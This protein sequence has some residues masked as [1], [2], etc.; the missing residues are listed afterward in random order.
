MGF[1]ANDPPPMSLF[2]TI[3]SSAEGEER[4]IWLIDDKEK[5]VGMIKMFKRLAMTL[6]AGAGIPDATRIVPGGSA[7]GVGHRKW[8]LNYVS[9]DVRPLSNPVNDANL[10][11]EALRTVGFQV[12]TVTDAKTRRR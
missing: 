4:F 6:T 7:R 10:I 9:Q 3:F 1:G 8:G 11:A 12:Q 5:Q 2:V